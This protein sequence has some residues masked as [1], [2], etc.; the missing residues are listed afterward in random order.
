MATLLKLI[1]REEGVDRDCSLVFFFHWPHG[2]YLFYFIR[3]TVI[4][5]RLPNC[6]ESAGT[7][8]LA[9][10]HEVRNTIVYGTM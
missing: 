4:Y 5:L 8:K 9:C 7:D 1:F 3:F 2:P 6:I 10:L